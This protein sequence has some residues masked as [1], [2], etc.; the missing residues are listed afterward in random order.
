MTDVDLSEQPVQDDADSRL[1]RM[2]TEPEVYFA[3]ARTAALI[4]A[5]ARVQRHLHKDDKPQRS[6]AR[7][8]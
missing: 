3:E 4:K 7:A 8:R 6:A 2:A 1:H 5:R